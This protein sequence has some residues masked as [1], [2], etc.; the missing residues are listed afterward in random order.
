M[1]FWTL[2]W[3]MIDYLP[4]VELVGGLVIG[5]LLRDGYIELRRLREL[6]HAAKWERLPGHANNCTC[7]PCADFVWRKR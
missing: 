4:M 6:N 3:A 7:K 5:W 1:T 2:F